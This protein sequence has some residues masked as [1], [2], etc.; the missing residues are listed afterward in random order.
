[1]GIHK[2]TSVEIILAITNPN[3]IARSGATD[4]RKSLVER[5]PIPQK[6]K[7]TGTRIIN[8]EIILINLF[9]YY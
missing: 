2:D 9:I 4:K 1:M 3:R 8:K 6:T 5:L 7:V